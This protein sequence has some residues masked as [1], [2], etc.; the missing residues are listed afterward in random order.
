MKK[1]LGLVAVLSLLAAAI[2][3]FAA[4]RTVRVADDVFAP[5]SLTVRKGD[6]VRF[7]W[8]GRH[9]HNVVVT[10]GPERFRTSI[11]RAPYTY[12]K[13]ITRRGTYRIV[14][15]IHPAMRMTLKAS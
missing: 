11:K 7:S 12:R 8:Q 15:T 5:K 3:A 6:V 10:Q 9:P 4:T 14:C 13:R 2:P 1:L